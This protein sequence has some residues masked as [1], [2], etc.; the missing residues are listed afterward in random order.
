MR[1]TV[2]FPLC[3]LK[4][5]LC[6]DKLGASI[7]KT[8]RKY[9]FS[10]VIAPGAGPS[11]VKCTTA[12]DGFEQYQFIL[13]ASSG[14][15]K[16]GIPAN[17]PGRHTS[18]G[19][20]A[21]VCV[22][23]DEDGIVALGPCVVPV[24]AN[25]R[26]TYDSTT[27]QL[28]VAGLTASA[29]RSGEDLCLT[30]AP[31][32]VAF[33]LDTVEDPP[34]STSYNISAGSRYYAT[35]ALGMLD[36]EG[37]FYFDK[38]SGYLYFKPPDAGV[39]EDV[40]ISLNATVVNLTSVHDVELRDMSILYAK[41]LAVLAS[42]VTRVSIVNVSIGLTSGQGMAVEGKDTLIEGCH[43]YGNGHL[44]WNTLHAWPYSSD[45][46]A[47]LVWSRYRMFSYVDR[48]WRSHHTHSGQ[49]HRSKL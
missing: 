45:K 38:G 24:P 41:S 21:D 2:L 8:Q 22:S 32:T 9:R 28:K 29:T 16:S 11:T 15:L 39:T 26:W 7:G 20:G 43:I 42:N 14:Q 4:T 6:Q 40:Y 3:T 19:F 18:Y 44:A 17:A 48:G 46:T 36:T 31:H 34:R 12:G 35:N 10:Q 27:K 5:K 47:L 23:T 1:E 25:Q 37:E 49:H 30:Y 33:E 13:N